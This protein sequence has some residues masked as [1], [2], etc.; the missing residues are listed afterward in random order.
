M[1]SN[2]QNSDHWL[3]RPS[4]IRG[5]WIGGSILLALTVFLQFFI[6]IKGYFVVDGWLGFGAVFGF[7]CCVAM[8]L[9]AKGLGR[10]IKRDDNFYQ[11]GNSDD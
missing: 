8:V 1:N 5:L 9:V 2:Q 10:F 4:T 11:G 7:L 6:K 3:V